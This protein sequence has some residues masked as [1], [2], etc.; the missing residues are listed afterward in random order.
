M[1]DRSFA[2]ALAIPGLAAWAAAFATP[3]PAILALH[4]D[5]DGDAVGSNLV[6]LRVLTE[7]G[8]PVTLISRDP[9][10][11]AFAFLPGFNRVQVAVPDRVNWAGFARFWALDLADAERIGAAIPFPPDLQVL[12]VDHHATNRGWGSLNLIDPKAASTTM[13]LDRLFTAL[14]IPLDAETATCL[15]HGLVTDTGTFAFTR[16]PDVFALAGRLI[17]AGADYAVIIASLRRQLDPALARAA[18]NVLRR[19]QVLNDP[20]MAV[21]T[22]P[23]ALWRETPD[24]V[25]GF[26]TGFAGRI[27]GAAFGVLVIEE[28]PGQSRIELRASSQA[29]DVSRIA[30]RLGGGG[31]RAAAG[32]QDLAG[33]I[34]L[35]VARICAAA[36]AD[37]ETA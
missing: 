25:V 8:H 11:S 12:V 36:L 13:L 30:K 32:A 18:G 15:L 7:R 31:H 3:R 29:W 23:Y 1:M 19:L 4:A 5:P 28:M 16:D 26:L 33:S 37:A 24:D 17:A 21:L 22:L 34:D 10:P 35:V 27:A 20:P 6:L 9:P 14:E 2:P